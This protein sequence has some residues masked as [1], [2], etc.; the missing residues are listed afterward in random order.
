LPKIAF[1]DQESDFPYAGRRFAAVEFHS[2]SAPSVP[3]PLGR[4]ALLGSSDAL[5]QSI[6]AVSATPE[7][8]D[9]LF[10][11]AWSRSPSAKIA[12]L[13]PQEIISPDRS[14]KNHTES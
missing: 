11:L 10:S 14:L 3:L 7:A 4:I 1:S 12:S 8:K 13:L 2:I 9:A 6:H 5:P